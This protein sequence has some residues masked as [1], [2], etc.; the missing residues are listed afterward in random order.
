MKLFML[1]LVLI[2]SSVNADDLVLV[3]MQ[4]GYAPPTYRL[5]ERHSNRP[6]YDQYGEM[7]YIRPQPIYMPPQYPPTVSIQLPPI[8]VRW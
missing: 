7:V 2:S 5:E 4:N 1:I 6:V 8:N 3:P